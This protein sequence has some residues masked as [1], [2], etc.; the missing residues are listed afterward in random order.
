MVSNGAW[1]N[2]IVGHGEEAPDQL[3]ANPR[4][5]RV[6][7][8][9]Q[10]RAL[11]QALSTVG[12]IQEVIV[13]RTTGHVVDGH[14]RVTLAMRRGEPTVPVKYVELSDDEERLALATL[15]PIAAMAAA[16]KDQLSSLLDEL[17]VGQPALEALLQEVAAQAGV[18]PPALG[19]E[20]DEHLADGVSLC[21]CP[22]C[23]HE[24]SRT[25]RID[26]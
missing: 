22:T 9:S 5:W 18:N 6:H 13:N 25:E 15:D 21:L 14:L 11:E 2:R 12:W 8:A 23:G 17:R 3:M 19:P 1:A 24:H 16:D 20:F 4:N 7:P 10:Q 26:S